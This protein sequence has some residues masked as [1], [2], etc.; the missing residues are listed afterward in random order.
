MFSSRIAPRRAAAP[1]FPKATRRVP[2]LLPFCRPG[3]SAALR[4]E[5]RPSPAASAVRPHVGSRRKFAIK[6]ACCSHTPQADGS[7]QWFTRALSG[8]VGSPSPSSWLRSPS[9]HGAPWQP[10]SSASRYSHGNKCY[11]SISHFSSED[12]EETLQEL[13]S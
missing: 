5:E 8:S 10:A 12:F 13:H 3:G 4:R 7:Q 11:S 6:F 9:S 2:W 1:P